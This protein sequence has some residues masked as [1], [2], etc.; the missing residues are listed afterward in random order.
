MRTSIF[1]T[2]LGV[3]LLLTAVSFS[4]NHFRGVF[5]L[6]TISVQDFTWA[7]FFVLPL[8]GFNAFFSYGAQRE[9]KGFQRFRRFEEEVVIPVACKFNF[10]S[11]LVISL[12]AGFGEEL[13]FRG[14]LQNEI[15]ILLSSV[16]FVL[17]HFGTAVK[18]FFDVAIAYLLVSVYLGLSYRISHHLWIPI[19]C[20]A[21]Y[22]LLVLCY[23]IKKIRYG[24]C[25]LSRAR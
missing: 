21:L 6:G 1:T 18:R 22:D 11:A 4:W 3:E 20:H 8:L 16:I 15:G 5:H 9:L 10:Y 7:F 19:L 25:G 13:F 24:V 2:L 23:L 17:L 12:A 14:L